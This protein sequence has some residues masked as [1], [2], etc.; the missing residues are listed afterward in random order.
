MYNIINADTYISKG[1]AFKIGAY[2]IAFTYGNLRIREN[3]P[4]YKDL[5]KEMMNI[6]EKIWI[7]Y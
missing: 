6:L 2:A 7:Y 3:F 5:K 4:C 1:K